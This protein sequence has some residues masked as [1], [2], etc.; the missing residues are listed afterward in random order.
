MFAKT[1]SLV[2]NSPGPNANIA[3]VAVMGMLGP[4]NFSGTLLVSIPID[5]DR[6]WINPGKF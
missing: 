6:F 3:F 4:P 5:S 2:C 1:V